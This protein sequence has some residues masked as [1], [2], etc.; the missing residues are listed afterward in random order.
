MDWTKL[1][2]EITV[3]KVADALSKRGIRV[4]IAENK[5]EVM[6]Q[7]MN[8]IPRHAELTTANS[9][10][11]D[12]I[13]MNDAIMNGE[14]VSLK[15]MLDVEGSAYVRNDAWRKAVTP[16][17]GVGSVHAITENGE[18]VVASSS[19]SQLSFYAYTAEKLVL[20]VGTQKI[21]KDLNQAIDRVYQFALPLVTE[22]EAR[23]GVVGTD[24]NKILIVEKEHILDRTT[25][26]L[27]KERLG[28]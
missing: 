7:V 27:V 11:L 14:F 16:Q 4:R 17:Y 28:F 18:M 13:G 22:Q 1:A 21:V 10:T 20:V 25:V 26:V 23:M 12:Q 24:V 9:I 6:E 2:D 8:L 3:R 5:R 19:G 15:E